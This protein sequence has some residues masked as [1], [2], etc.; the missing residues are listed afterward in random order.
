MPAAPQGQPPPPCPGPVGCWHGSQ[1]PWHAPKRRGKAQRE[2]SASSPSHGTWALLW[3]AH[4]WALL[5]VAEGV[6][7]PAEKAQGR[8]R[9]AGAHASFPSLALLG[10]SKAV[11]HQWKPAWTKCTPRIHTQLALGAPHHHP[12]CPL[13]RASVS[14]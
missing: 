5:L 9:G 7:S 14:K 6:V 1:A 12:H 13:Q 4:G 11:K 3:L 10:P 2:M 8:R